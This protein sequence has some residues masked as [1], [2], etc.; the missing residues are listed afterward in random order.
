M[1]GV[2]ILASPADRC[3]HGAGIRMAVRQALGAGVEGRPGWP[4]AEVRHH[5]W[6]CAACS[7]HV[8][9]REGVQPLGVGHCRAHVLQDVLHVEGHLG[10]AALRGDGDEAGLV[11]SS[12]DR[13]LDAKLGGVQ[14][15]AAEDARDSVRH[16]PARSSVLHGL[17]AQDIVGGAKV[18]HLGDPVAPEAE[19]AEGH[20]GAGLPVGDLVLEER[21]ALE[22]RV[23]AGNVPDHA[24]VL[25]LVGANPVVLPNID[26]CVWEGRGVATEEL[27]LQVG[28]R[29]LSVE[30]V[31][32]APLEGGRDVVPGRVAVALRVVHRVL[33]LSNLPQG[34]APR[35]AGA[36]AA[37][38]IGEGGGEVDE[39]AH[40]PGLL[41]RLEHGIKGADD[42]PGHL[43]G[44]VSAANRRVGRHLQVGL[45]Q[46]V[47]DAECGVVPPVHEQEALVQILQVLRLDLGEAVVAGLLAIARGLLVERVVAHARKYTQALHVS[48]VEEGG[49]VVVR[50][51]AVQAHDVCAEGSHVPQVAPARPTPHGHG[52]AAHPVVLR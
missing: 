16:Q 17:Q 42:G 6:E 30:T 34:R 14:R 7:A 38:G 36:D 52:L 31:D 28:G 47:H 20:L 51:V 8:P 1:G 5:R 40:D 11:E 3:A 41:L 4:G 24:K 9:G 18:G 25:G 50:V 45:I 27:V 37:D 22:E 48:L 21:D 29:V 32:P 15:G 44:P 23:P 26:R 2:C 19:H 33:Q 10:G 13:V 43:H 35:E 49:V 39:R 46:D 12:T